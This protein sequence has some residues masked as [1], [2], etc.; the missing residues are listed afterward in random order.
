MKTTFLN[1]TS[2]L[3]KKIQDIEKKLDKFREEK[4]KH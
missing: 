2:K 3:P 1:Q 4:T